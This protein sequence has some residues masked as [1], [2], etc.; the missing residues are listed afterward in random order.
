[1]LVPKCIYPKSIFEKCTRLACLLSFASLFSDMDTRHI[2]L[3]SSLKKE[4]SQIVTEIAILVKLPAI[5]RFF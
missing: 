3:P 1:M 4:I 5:Q 2:G